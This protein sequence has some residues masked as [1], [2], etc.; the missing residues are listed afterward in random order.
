M[1]LN[2]R[3]ET[4]V[5]R[6]YEQLLA[7]PA[8]QRLGPQLKC[9]IKYIMTLTSNERAVVDSFLRRQKLAL[10]TYLLNKLKVRAAR[11]ERLKQKAANDFN[12]FSS[13]LSIARTP[14][15]IFNVA[16]DILGDEDCQ[17]ALEDIIGF[18]TRKQINLPEFDG[19]FSTVS[20]AADA[21]YYKLQ[22]LERAVDVNSHI[23]HAVT[24]TINTIDAYL[25]VLSAVDAALT[26]IE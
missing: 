11:F 14:I 9:V 4:I 23:Q 6:L 3:E 26:V 18:L 5:N 17:P 19:A 24:G 8:A 12:A 10:Q 20:G 15:G 7:V 22:Q 21:A 13:K 16:G 2:S 25:S 1:P